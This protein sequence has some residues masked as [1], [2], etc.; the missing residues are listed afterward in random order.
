MDHEGWL[1]RQRDDLA[2]G[3]L[4]RAERIRIGWLVEADMAVANLQEGQAFRFLRRGLA[5]DAQRVRDAAG[6]GPEH[7]G[8]DPGHAFEN[9]API[10]AVITIE[11]VH[12][13][14]P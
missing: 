6:N 9:F 4:Q 11:T 8:A 2:H 5:H 3:L 7:P 13:I 1:G 12:R 14:L 10:Y